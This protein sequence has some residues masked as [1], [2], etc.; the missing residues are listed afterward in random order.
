MRAV[1]IPSQYTR[2][3]QRRL[4]RRQTTLLFDNHQTKRF[5]IDNGL[6]QG[7]PYS[8]ICY[9]IYNAGL[10]KIPKTR[11]RELMLLFVDDAGVAVLAKTFQET[12]R[13]LRD[14]MTPGGVLEW[15]SNH[16]C[17]FGIAKFQLLD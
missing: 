11:M 2:W 16:N 15:A 4:S 7:D 12:H 10:L 1:G 13:K 6:D 3:M 17:E 8:V 9:L 14:I 5:T